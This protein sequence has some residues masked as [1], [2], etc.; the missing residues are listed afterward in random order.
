[1]KH[2]S[3][4]KGVTHS[5]TFECEVSD[6]MLSQRTLVISLVPYCYGTFLCA[7][8]SQAHRYTRFLY[9][10]LIFFLAR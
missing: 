5:V 8:I 1:M 4:H 6:V 10:F 9:S 3:S 2:L 7:V